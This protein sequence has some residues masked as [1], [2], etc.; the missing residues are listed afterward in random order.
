MTIRT[1]LNQDDMTVLVSYYYLSSNEEQSERHPRLQNLAGILSRSP[2]TLAI[3]LRR[4]RYT[5]TRGQSGMKHDNFLVGKIVERY[6][7]N[8]DRAHRAA[9][10]ILGDSVV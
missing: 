8:P 9:S 6:R 5:V 10:E 4:M 7:E 2:G 1:P 3:T